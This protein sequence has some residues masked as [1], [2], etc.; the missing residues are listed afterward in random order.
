[1][2]FFGKVGRLGSG[3]LAL[4]A[5]AS[6]LGGSASAHNTG[7]LP[8]AAAAP[9]QC[10]L[11]RQTHTLAGYHGT[12]TN[13]VVRTLPDLA[14]W[15]TV[16]CTSVS[17]TVPAGGVG[18]VVLT[19]RGKFDASGPGWLLARFGIVPTAGTGFYSAL[20]P[21][22]DD[23]DLLALDTARGGSGDWSAHTFTQSTHAFCSGETTCTFFVY[24]QASL[25]QLGGVIK[26]DDTVVQAKVRYASMFGMPS[27]LTAVA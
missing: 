19:Y 25:R 15:Q 5:A 14:G 27:R 20:L 9:D 17:F 22:Q 8:R 7:E 4:A 11:E 12:L 21:N 16:P 13:N 2:R 24:V 6:L 23:T 1:M 10:L 3:A 26:Y 18:S